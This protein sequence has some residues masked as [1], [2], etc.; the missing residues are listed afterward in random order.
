MKHS[1]KNKRTKSLHLA[2]QNLLIYSSSLDL[3]ERK[4]QCASCPI[5]S[6]NR[7]L[8]VST[9][10]PSFFLWLGEVS[11]TD[12]LRLFLIYRCYGRATCGEIVEGIDLQYSTM[13]NSMVLFS[14]YARGLVTTIIVDTIEYY[15]RHISIEKYIVK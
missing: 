13:N 10:S 11:F 5:Y 15:G 6:S 2:K 14:S 3:A 8:A 4:C 7:F 12:A 1:G 9:V